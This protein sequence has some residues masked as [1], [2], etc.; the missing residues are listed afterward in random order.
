MLHEGPPMTTVITPQRR[1]ETVGRGLLIIAALTAAAAA[2][3]AAFDLAGVD[4][5]LAML[6]AWRAF[7]LATF[8]GL[9]ALLAWRPRSLPGVFEL[10]IAHKLAL[11]FYA[12]ARP[13]AEDATT[14]L[15][16]DGLL[17]VALIAAYIAVG[18]H[19]WLTASDDR[20]DGRAPAEGDDGLIRT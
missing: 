4:A 9:F 19:R 8:A 2:T 12:L 10:A 20:E 3:G 1:R 11:T 16:A 5:D 7:G 6:A 18:G 14:V 17:A 13:D 15:V